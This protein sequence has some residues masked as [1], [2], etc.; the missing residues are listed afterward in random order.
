MASLYGCNY[1]KYIFN[2]YSNYLVF[3]TLFGFNLIKCILVLPGNIMVNRYLGLSATI[4]ANSYLDLIGIL[5]ISNNNRFVRLSDTKVV[6]NYVE[7]LEKLYFSNN[8]Q[9]LN[10]FLAY[11]GDLSGYWFTLFPP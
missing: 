2:I 4:L 3:S 1:G 5:L 7:G 8:F 9:G 11:G 10:H 6:N